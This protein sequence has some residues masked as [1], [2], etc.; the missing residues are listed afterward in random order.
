MTAAYCSDW[1]SAHALYRLTGDTLPA[2]DPQRVAL[3]RFL[4]RAIGDKLG[5]I[6]SNR[7]E[8]IAEAKSGSKMDYHWV[9]H[10]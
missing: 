9:R 6:R 10:L 3:E 2:D 8:L 7:P 5:A 4:D 1:A